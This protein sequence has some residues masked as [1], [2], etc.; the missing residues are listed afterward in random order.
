M[1]ISLC[2]Y[3]IDSPVMV[4]LLAG[5]NLFHLDRSL[6]CQHECTVSPEPPLGRPVSLKRMVQLISHITVTLV[7]S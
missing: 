6:Q 1:A 7:M 2:S 3:Q 4:G 5:W